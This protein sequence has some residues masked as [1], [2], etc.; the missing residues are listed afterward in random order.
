MSRD[1][2]RERRRRST[3]THRTE[4]T[5][6]QT[7]MRRW[8]EQ[9]DKQTHMRRWTEQDRLTKMAFGNE[10]NTH[11]KVDRTDRHRKMAFGNGN[12]G[13]QNFA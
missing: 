12:L 13:S 11:E 2:G 7:H 5:D 4:Q 9:T 3:N 6:K 10:T 1:N 8:T